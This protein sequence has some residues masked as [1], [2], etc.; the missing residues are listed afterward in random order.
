MKIRSLG[1]IHVAVAGAFT[2]IISASKP[3]V[4]AQTHGTGSLPVAQY[5]E[6]AQ[7]GEVSAMI[8]LGMLYDTGNGVPK[9]RS[10]AIYWFNQAAQQ[11]DETSLWIIGRAYDD[12]NGVPASQILAYVYYD[13]AVRQ[14]ASIDAPPRL[15]R[16]MVTRKLTADQLSQAKSIS[17]A[18]KP[19]RPLPSITSLWSQKQFG[20]RT[21]A[22]SVVREGQTSQRWEYKSL[23]SSPMVSIATLDGE[24]QSGWELVT[25]IPLPSPSAGIPGPLYL[26][27]KRKY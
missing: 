15:L 18:W 2:L 20:S 12:G 4:A 8:H 13:L 25:T 11:G 3:A 10:L 22:M 17:S 16:D 7:K 5:L 23:T 19:E 9:D 21:T 1:L 24:G 26:I 6:L 27:F 14:G